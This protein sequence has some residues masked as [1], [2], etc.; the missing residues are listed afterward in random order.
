[1]LSPQGVEPTNQEFIK[2]EELCQPFFLQLQ[3]FVH[4][5]IHTKKEYSR[6]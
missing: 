3:V 2:L 4:V 1:M 6:E 5:Y